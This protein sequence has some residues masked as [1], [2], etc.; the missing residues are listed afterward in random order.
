MI[1][2]SEGNGTARVK[3]HSALSKQNTLKIKLNAFFPTVPDQ[4]F[5]FFGNTTIWEVKELIAQSIAKNIQ[6]IGFYY[7][8]TE[9]IPEA[10]NGKTLLELKV[11]T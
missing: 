7:T 4:F 9:E 5:V 1:S 3:A 6:Y 11:I 8:H 10:D 2:D